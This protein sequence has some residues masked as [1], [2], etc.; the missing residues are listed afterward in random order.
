MPKLRRFELHTVAE[1]LQDIRALREQGYERGGN[2]SLSQVCEHLSGTIRVELDGSIKPMPWVVR[3]TMG[4][5]VFWL[6]TSRTLHGLS[7]VP[8]LKQLVPQPVNGDQDDPTKIDECLRL[9]EE[10]RD[11]TAPIPPYP[12]ATGVTL[13]KW[14][15]MMVVHAQHHLEFLRPLD[16]A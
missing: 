7:G 12:L 13:E 10:V 6:F 9:H 8:T 16:A 3:A 15:L 5:L 2:W 4:N 1:V 14:R 11:R